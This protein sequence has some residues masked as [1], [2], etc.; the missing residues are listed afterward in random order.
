MASSLQIKQLKSYTSMD[1]LKEA[2]KR[3]GSN[4]SLKSQVVSPPVLACSARYSKQP[5]L[6]SKKPPA[7]QVDEMPPIVM[8][9]LVSNARK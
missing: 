5:S 2:S 8:I 7:S 6:K 4:S 1:D 3:D 9:P